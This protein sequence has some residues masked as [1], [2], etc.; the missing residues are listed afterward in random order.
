MEYGPHPGRGIAAGPGGV[1]GRRGDDARQPSAHRALAPREFLRGLDAGRA[2]A[3][4]AALRA[5]G[6]A[7]LDAVLALVTN[8]GQNGVGQNLMAGLLKDVS[9][10]GDP[11]VV[12]KVIGTLLVYGGPSVG[13]KI[14]N[15]PDN[16][17]LDLG[18]LPAYQF[19]LT[20]I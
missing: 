13:V 15:F 9:I 12:G 8:I 10:N 7:V 20:K 6:G 4:L 2:G 17:Q 16:D 19:D 11:A 3:G 5:L 18:D 14:E 1:C